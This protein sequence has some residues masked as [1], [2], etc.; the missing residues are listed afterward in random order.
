[1]RRLLGLFVVLAGVTAAQSGDAGWAATVQSQY[2]VVPNITYQT[3]SNFETKLAVYAPRNVEGPRPTLVYIHGGGWVGGSKES[4]VLQLL[5]FLNMGMTVVNVEYRL[6]GVAL[7]PAAVADC[8]CAL[9]WVYSHAKEYGFDLQKLVLSGGSAGGHLALTTGMLDPSWGFDYACPQGQPEM[10]IPVAAIVNFYGIT[11]VADLL[12]G[13][14][15]KNYA[16]RWL[17][18]LEN[19]KELAGRLSPLSYVRPG[20]PPVLTIHGDA[21]PTVPYQHAIMLHK[22]LD[23][24]KVPNELLTI[25]GGKH[26]NFS[27]PEYST[28]D[29]AIRVFLKKHGIL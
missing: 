25:P 19:R 5:P 13:P 3:A 26:G 9:R 12:E 24:K 18:Y 4:V 29:K 2:R 16:V 7:A 23:A 8:R 14:N 1:M 22:A 27:A 11:D 15:Q 10:K 17:G 21:D 6:G 20:L 28:I